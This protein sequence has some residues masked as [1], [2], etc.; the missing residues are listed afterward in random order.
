MFTLEK[1]EKTYPNEVPFNSKK[2]DTRES[3]AFY[4]YILSAHGGDFQEKPLEEL[5]DV[6]I[7][8]AY[9]KLA[10]RQTK[11]GIFMNNVKGEL[12]NSKTEWH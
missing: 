4:K 8:K 3:S 7:V 1:L 10:T 6:E 12:L 11:E 2:K 9:S 5:F